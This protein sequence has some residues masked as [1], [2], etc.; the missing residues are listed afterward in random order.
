MSICQFT[1]TRQCFV[2]R[3]AE[4]FLDPPKY[5][6]HGVY[7]LTSVTGTGTAMHYLSIWEELL[8]DSIVIQRY[9]TVVI[10]YTGLGI[11]HESFYGLGHL[12]I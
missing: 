7:I 9:N 3:P 1:V 2:T 8:S 10:L 5:S 4:N 11:L 12:L 6:S